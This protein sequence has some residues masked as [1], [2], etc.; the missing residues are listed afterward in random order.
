MTVLL[1]VLLAAGTQAQEPDYSIIAFNHQ[2]AVGMPW[3]L[4]LTALG[5]PQ[6]VA[7]VTNGFG[8]SEWWYYPADFTVVLQ[9]G[10]VGSWWKGHISGLAYP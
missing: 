10:R 2:V 3:Q 4:V 7:V 9:N 1:A 6:R 8:T 5:R